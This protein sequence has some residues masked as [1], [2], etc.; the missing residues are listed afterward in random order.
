MKGDG[1]AEKLQ[2]LIKSAYVK[3]FNMLPNLEVI[4]KNEL[5]DEFMSVYGLSSRLAESAA[6]N[7]LWLCSLAEIKTGVNMSPRKEK[8][9]AKIEIQKSGRKKG[10]VSNSDRPSNPSSN[11]DANV[12]KFE[13]P[14]NSG[15]NLLIYFPNGLSQDIVRRDMA[16]FEEYIKFVKKNVLE[17]NEDLNEK[18]EKKTGGVA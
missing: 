10:E 6:P 8:K 9:A 7:F 14:L 16:T 3:I 17:Q 13:L 5:H 11:N 12:K 1:K 18:N 4:S 2:E 15:S